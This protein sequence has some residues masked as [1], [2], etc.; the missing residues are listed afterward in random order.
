[1]ADE[2]PTPP[3]GTPVGEPKPSGEGS[4]P[5][6]E[7]VKS[8]PEKNPLYPRV[9][10]LS[11]KNKDLQVKVDEYTDAERK[12]GEEEAKK[13]GDYEKIIEAK[14]QEIA[15]L[16]P[17]A[18]LYREY[19]QA[20]RET[21]KSELPEQ[22]HKQIESIQSLVELEDFAKNLGALNIKGAVPPKG[23]PAGAPRGEPLKKLS[24]MTAKERRETHDERLA[25]HQQ[26]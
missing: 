9:Q 22:F 13:R 8:D 17:G 4:L 26:T 24:E 10:E 19:N 1:M 5:A 6:P 16:K 23:T 12:K 25:Q 7:G 18:E 21:L 15:A 20:R 3:G 14:D 11:Q 2:K